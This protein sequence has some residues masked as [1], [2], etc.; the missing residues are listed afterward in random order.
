MTSINGRDVGARIAVAGKYLSLVAASAVTLLPLVAVALAALKTERESANGGP[1][2]LPGNWLNLHNFEVA[3]TQGHMLRAFANTAV[4]LVFSITGT[5]IIGSMTAY[6]IDRFTFRFRRLVIASFLVAAL[7]PSVTTQVATFQIIDRLG[8]FNTRGAPIVLYMGTDI[9]SI[10]IFLQFMRSIP[11]S[12]DEAARIDG[13][14][15]FRIYRTV[16]LPLLKPAI[17]TVVIV[18]GVVVYNDFYVPFLYMPSPDLGVISTSLFYF[19]GPHGAHWEIICAGAV[20]VIVPTLIVF[21]FLQRY[22]YNGFT[23]GA[24]K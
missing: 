23:R 11:V 22:I 24:T 1:L 19:K 3:F 7:V 6:A 8:L 20:L 4:V 21:L 2:D 12:L 16:I 14:S 17:A 15:S 18:K 10:I 13:A 5:V 9:I